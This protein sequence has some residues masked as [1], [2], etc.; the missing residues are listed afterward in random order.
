MTLRS[1]LAQAGL[2]LLA[3]LCAGCEPRITD[4]DI[5][6][7][8]LRDLER[9]AAQRERPGG[10]RT[11][12]LIDPRSPARYEAEHLPGARNM[13][14]TQVGKETD[15]GV[16]RYERLVVYGDDPTTPIARAMAKAMMSAGY[17]GVRHFAG[18]L[19]EWKEAGLPTESARPPAEP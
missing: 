11:L 14:T 15:P 18:G 10:E 9:L 2:V 5:V 12:L 16:A 1:G 4:D 19:R 6:P 13:Q 17:K 7:I 8:S 3:A